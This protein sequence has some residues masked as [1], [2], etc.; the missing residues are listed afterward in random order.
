MQKSLL[1]GLILSC[2]LL[3]GCGGSSSST[4]ATTQTPATKTQTVQQFDKLKDEAK[5]LTENLGNV[6]ANVQETAQKIETQLKEIEQKAKDSGVSEK[7]I[8]DVKAKLK[9]A[10]SKLKK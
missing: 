4:P 8:A 3:S 5:K 10:L 6:K 7:E 9:G 1:A 2:V